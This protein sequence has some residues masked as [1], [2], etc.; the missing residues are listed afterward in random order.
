MPVI[1]QMIMQVTMIVLFECQLMRLARVFVV[2]MIVMMRVIM[3]VTVIVPAGQQPRAR[4]IDREPK[5]GDRDR[6]VEADRNGVEQ[7]LDRL[8]ADQKRDHRQH[9]G[10]GKSGEVAEFSGAECEAAIVRIFA[11]IGIRQRGQQQRAGMRRHVQSVGD[12]G[13]RAK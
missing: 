12:K 6:L 8:V 11:G 7:A 5:D 4:D 2:G 10:A 13:Q 1:V 3:A 9:D